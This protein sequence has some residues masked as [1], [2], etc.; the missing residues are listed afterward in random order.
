MFKRNITTFTWKLGPSS[1][2]KPMPI[3]RTTKVSKSTW[4][5]TVK[6]KGKYPC[7][8]TNTSSQVKNSWP[9]D[10]TNLKVDSSSLMILFKLNP[11]E[12]CDETSPSKIPKDYHNNNGNLW[13]PLEIFMNF[14][15]LLCR[16]HLEDKYSE[17]ASLWA[18]ETSS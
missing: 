10:V 6:T 12:F 2:T 11:E 3:I 8:N 17:L 7:L 9:S 5:T 18:T 15:E 13:E 1:S 14:R 4:I 16:R